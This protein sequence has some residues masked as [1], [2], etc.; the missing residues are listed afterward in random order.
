MAVCSKTHKCTD[1]FQEP[2]LPPLEMTAQYHR[3]TQI[4]V[5]VVWSND[6]L[7]VRPVVHSDILCYSKAMDLTYSSKPVPW[8][9]R[10]YISGFHKRQLS[11]MQLQLPWRVHHQ[12]HP[13]RAYLPS[14]IGTI[15]CR[16]W[17]CF[18]ARRAELRLSPGP[19]CHSSDKTHTHH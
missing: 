17:H 16:K 8:S 7:S 2:Y 19:F 1:Q 5:H 12:H 14:L 10:H 13:R 6:R 3:H 18:L 15:H 9:T 11:C 4:V